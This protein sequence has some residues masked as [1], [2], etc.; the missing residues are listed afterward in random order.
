MAKN[1]RPYLNP[2]IVS[3][4]SLS[5]VIKLRKIFY[6]NKV[7]RNEKLNAL[8]RVRAFMSRGKLPHAIE[9]TALLVSVRSSDPAYGGSETNSDILQLSYSMSLVRFVNGL[10]DQFQQSDYAI[11]L[12]TLARNLN[13]PSYFVELRHMSTHELLLN[14]GLLRDTA[15][16]AM[17]WLYDN[18]WVQISEESELEEFEEVYARELIETRERLIAS[19]LENIKCYR[20]IR[21]LD[22]SRIIK[23]GDTSELGMEYWKSVKSLQNLDTQSNDLLLFVFLFKNVLIRN[24]NN[25]KIDEEK[26]VKLNP[27][28]LK[29]YEPLLKEFSGDFSLRLLLQMYLSLSLQNESKD[30]EIRNYQ[31]RP[32]H[33]SEIDQVFEWAKY[34]T[35]RIL[36]QGINS[37]PQYNI[38]SAS[39]LFTFVIDKIRTV[40]FGMREDFLPIVRDSI[41]K[42]FGKISSETVSELNASVARLEKDAKVQSFAPPPSLDK[43]LSEEA[44]ESLPSIN[45]HSKKQKR[46]TNDEPYFFFEEHEYWSPKAFGVTS[47]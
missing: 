39:Q 13:L 20:K 22:M 46:S 9:I 40:H 35:H 43:L 23:Y 10:L 17:S 30:S 24:V 37:Y 47:L 38:R 36:N 28:V 6:D 4:K 18:Y 42:I 29:L 45:Q 44:C 33:V 34:L 26:T 21:K 31:I 19:A 16:D 8:Q 3:Y 27:A 5:E 15:Q 1:K 12:H 2:T 14:I 11:P 41:A 7:P 25:L 32:L